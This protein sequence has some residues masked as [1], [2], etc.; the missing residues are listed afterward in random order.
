VYG[1][2]DSEETMDRILRHNVHNTHDMASLAWEQYHEDWGP[3]LDMDADQRNVEIY[4]REWK[5]P[6]RPVEAYYNFQFLKEALD[7]LGLLRTFDPAME[8][9]IVDP[10]PY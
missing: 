1:S 4:T 10:T 6:P 8:A 2:R 9:A 7:E 5:L 3:V